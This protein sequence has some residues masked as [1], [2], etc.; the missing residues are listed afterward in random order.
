MAQIKVVIVRVGEQPQIELIND[1]LKTMQTIV[2]G[3]I[4]VQNLDCGFYLTCNE[5]GIRLKLAPNGCS[6]LGNYFITKINNTG[7]YISL[8]DK[9]C[10]MVLAYVVLHRS[11]KFNSVIKTIEELFNNQDL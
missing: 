11:S 8:N 7:D 10:E 6:I 9:E 4:E 1:D 5:D 3:Y 2:G